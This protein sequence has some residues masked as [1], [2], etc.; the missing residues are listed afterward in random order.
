MQRNHKPTNYAA[1][2]LAKASVSTVRGAHRKFVSCVY[3]F[4]HGAYTF[5][6]LCMAYLWRPSPVCPN[7]IRKPPAHKRIDM[8]TKYYI[9]SVMP[10]CLLR[11]VSVYIV[12][13]AWRPNAHESAKFVISC[14]RAGRTTAYKPANTSA[15]YRHC[16]TQPTLA[17]CNTSPTKRHPMC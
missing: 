10:S 12:W 8:Q 16:L 3:A 7:A 5:Y 14:H 13:R 11:L 15:L 2:M 6:R 4:M 9:Y 1:S 17:E